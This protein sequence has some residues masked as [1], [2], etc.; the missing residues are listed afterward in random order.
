MVPKPTHSAQAEAGGS[1]P[2]ASCREDEN[3]D[4]LARWANLASTLS[5][6]QQQG[7]QPFTAAFLHRLQSTEV[8]GASCWLDRG[9]ASK[10]WLS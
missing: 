1:C 2:A 10:V 6:E 4:S 5:F 8:T 3:T 7:L 9:K